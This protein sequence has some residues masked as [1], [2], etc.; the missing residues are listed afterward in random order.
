MHRRSAGKEAWVLG[1]QTPARDG[2]ECAVGG[3][4]GGSFRMDFK[5]S[6]MSLSTALVTRSC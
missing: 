4:V 6:A 2:T 5:D 1:Q 3:K